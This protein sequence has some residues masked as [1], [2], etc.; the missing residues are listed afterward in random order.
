M[1]YFDEITDI[2]NDLSAVVD[3]VEAEERAKRIKLS[4]ES[5]L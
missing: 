4:G 1:D 3:T 5:L 2:D